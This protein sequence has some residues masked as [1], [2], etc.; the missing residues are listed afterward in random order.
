MAL[1]VDW[2]EAPLQ[3][4]FS[5][6]VRSGTRFVYRSAF[7]TYSH[8]TQMTA[9][10]LIDEAFED[11]QRDIRKRK[12]VVLSRV[13]G[14][15][16]WLKNDYEILSRGREER[17]VLR[18]GCSDKLASA[19][20]GA[21]RSFYSTYDISVR[22]KGRSRLPRAKIMNKRMKVGPEEIKI[23]VQHTRTPRDRA[24]ILTM[25]QSGL[26][27]SS[28]CSLKYGDVAEVL[29]KN[30]EPL[31]IEVQ[32]PKT[33][34]E[35][36]T[37]IGQ[38]ASEALRAYLNDVRKRGIVSSSSSPLFIT[39][40]GQEPLKTHNVQKM[41]KEVAITSGLVSE[42][43]NFNPLGSHSLRESFGSIMINSGV[44]D[45]IV[46]FWLGHAIGEMSEAYKS[47][48]FESVKKMYIH[49]ENLLSISQPTVDIKEVERKI[50]FEIDDRDKQLQF[51]V[52]NLS[53][54]NLK[55]RS[56]LENLKGEL[57]EVK[58]ANEAFERMTDLTRQDFLA[59]R[60]LVQ[61]FL[62]KKFKEE[63]RES[64]TDE[65]NWRREVLAQLQ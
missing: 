50:R 48:Q 15:Y 65:A 23:L 7:K 14:F 28:L 39:E 4:W 61:D 36:Y 37:F 1:T 40:R 32:R 53:I 34:V 3:K 58:R 10:Q 62:A 60:E 19:Y 59:L 9:T 56:Q 55:N 24:I 57:D 8:Y 43:K 64:F 17:K 11:S 47:I 29:I 27:V 21:I 44:P 54:E 12:D 41:L 31:K 33:G 2:D 49:R 46:D 18:R 13:I 26:D 35:F 16:N 42:G 51:L 52:N 6:I 63:E 20:V 38:D 45:A 5:M 25:F 30:G 22:L